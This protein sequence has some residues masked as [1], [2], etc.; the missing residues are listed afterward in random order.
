MKNLFLILILSLIQFTAQS[1]T[2][3]SGGNSLKKELPTYL[4]DPLTYQDLNDSIVSGYGFV[5]P[6]D[7][8]SLVYINELP[9]DTIVVGW[10]DFKVKSAKVYKS[11]LKELIKNVL[12]LDTPMDSLKRQKLLTKTRTIDD[13]LQVFFLRKMKGGIANGLRELKY[14]NSE[15]RL[16]KFVPTTYAI[17]PKLVLFQSTEL[18]TYD[19][20]TYFLNYNNQKAFKRSVKRS[21]K[22]C[23]KIIEKAE[24]GMY[25]PDTSKNLKQFGEDFKTLCEKF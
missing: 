7:S 25:Y 8:K 22:K 13:T 3:I 18:S 23:S 5:N 9:T 10:K 17:T 6:I 14:E 1:Q 21:F 24:S 15:I 12:A 11:K 16:F 4:F 20:N 19:S 2:F